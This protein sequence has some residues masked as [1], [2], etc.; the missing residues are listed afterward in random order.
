MR[1]LFYFYALDHGI[2]IGRRGFLSLNLIRTEGM[3][4]SFLSMFESFI[5]DYSKGDEGDA[6]IIA[7]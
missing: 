6:S 7:E 1:D 2:V 4:D 3:I 5:K